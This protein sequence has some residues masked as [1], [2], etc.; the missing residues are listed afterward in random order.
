MVTRNEV[1]PGRFLKA[2]DLKGRPRVVQIKDAPLETLKA[3]DGREQVKIVLYFVGAKKAL[4]L[5]KVHWDAIA[6]IA[7]DDTEGWPGHRIELYPTKTEIGGKLVDCI[8]V[9]PPHKQQPQSEQSN[10]EIEIPY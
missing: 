1:F 5:S 7:G 2:E 4:P 3:P 8:R 9:R 10:E 6:P